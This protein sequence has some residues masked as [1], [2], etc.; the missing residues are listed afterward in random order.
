MRNIS[1][2]TQ[3]VVDA[4]TEAH[5]PERVR[6][7]SIEFWHHRF[8]AMPGTKFDRVVTQRQIASDKGTPTWD[9]QQRLVLSF[10]ERETGAIHYAAGW[11]GPAKW[12]SGPAVEWHADE[13]QRYAQ[14]VKDGGWGY[15]GQRAKW[16]AEHPVESTPDESPW[17]VKAPERFDIKAFAQLF[18]EARLMA[19]ATDSEHWKA[20]L[21][22]YRAVWATLTGNYDNDKQDDE[23][24][25]V[26]DRS[27]HVA[28]TSDLI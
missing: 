27:G 2:Y 28:Y 26:L 11:A 7:G 3:Q 5:T 19:K 18:F 22:I 20:R 13:A 9:N 14:F 21:A 15:Q 24:N 17:P 4:L 1:K 10:V 12:V 6:E 8:Y 23:V 16:E 25:A